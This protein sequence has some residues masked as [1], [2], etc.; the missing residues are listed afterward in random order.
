MGK[1]LPEG[2]IDEITTLMGNYAGCFTLSR[3][4][5]FFFF[6]V[7]DFDSSPFTTLYT[8]LF[9]CLVP[10]GPPRQ[11]VLSLTQVS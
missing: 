1:V 9:C 6:V 8:C 2:Q 11:Y 5:F 4:F 3:L 7:V 10:D